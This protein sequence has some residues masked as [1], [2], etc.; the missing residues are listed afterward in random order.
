MMARCVLFVGNDSGLKHIAAAVGTPVVEINA[1]RANG[2]AT[3]H[4]SPARFGAWGVA[5]QIVQPPPGFGD[6]AIEEVSLTDV[7]VSVEKLMV[8]I[9]SSSR[10]AL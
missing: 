10:A 7:Q 3:H 2:P 8:E 1:L 9:A 4:V 5:Q 6:C